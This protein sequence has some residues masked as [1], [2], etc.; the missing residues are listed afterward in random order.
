M[1]TQHRGTLVT[2]VS[3]ETHR[4]VV[5]VLEEGQRPTPN[6]TS[7]SYTPS[8]SHSHSTQFHVS[9]PIYAHSIPLNFISSHFS[10]K[11][12]KSFFILYS[13]A[14]PV[15]PRVFGVTV[16]VNCCP[17]VF[18]III[19]AHGVLLQA[20]LVVRTVPRLAPTHCNPARATA[21]STKLEL[22]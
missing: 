3:C 18:L 19:E 2:L 9:F 1:N 13:S 21:S 11:L 10:T 17:S 15:L 6:T 12:N 20:S 16:T 4:A 22:M 5:G 8:Q 14:A 7:R